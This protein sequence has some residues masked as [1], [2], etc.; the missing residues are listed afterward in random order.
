MSGP[1]RLGWPNRITIVRM[2]LIG[3]FVVCLL[4]MNERSE[5]WL[6]YLA[7]AVFA[8]MAF[9]DMLDGYLAR[10][11]HDE[12]PLGRFLD[13][14]ADKLLIT[15]AVVI[16]SVVGV[17]DTSGIAARGLLALPNW[18]AVAAIGKDL[19][20]SIGF[21][22]VYLS[23]GRVFIRPRLVG[24]CCTVIQ[25]SLVLSMLLWVDL[26]VWAG[27]LPKFLWWLATILAALAAIDY[28]AI[29]NRYV[30]TVAAETKKRGNG[31]TVHGQGR[32]VV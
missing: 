5:A 18:V 27:Y 10:R 4:N 6:R 28:I 15:A 8:L 19:V 20:V 29:G 14:L 12:S 1:F 13:P 25:T 30:A 9:S 26:P 17:R 7:V 32:G 3:P 11:L 24:K 21:T 31:E 23:T 16:L 22:L 2:L